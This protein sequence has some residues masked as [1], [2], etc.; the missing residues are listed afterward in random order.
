[1]SSES[2]KKKLR[3]IAL[4]VLRPGPPKPTKDVEELLISLSMQPKH[5]HQ[6]YRIFH[7]L[8]QGASDST[9]LESGQI[10][11]ESL[12]EIVP[13]RKVWVEKIL[14]NLCQLGACTDVLDWDTF[15]YLML[16]F[17]SLSKV[18]L[19]QC[20][21]FIIVKEVKSWTVHFLT[22]V[23]LQE[24]YEKYAKCPIASFSTKDISFARHMPLSRYYISDFVESCHRFSQLLNPAIH[25]QRAFQ[26]ALPSMDFWNNY[27]RMEVYNRK[28]TLDFFKLRKTH[29]FLR[30]IPPF[31]E[32][33]D[34][35]LPDTLGA[36]PI[37]AEQWKLRAPHYDVSQGVW[38]G[39]G[40]VPGAIDDRNTD[41]QKQQ[42][43]LSS[44]SSPLLIQAPTGMKAPL[45]AG[46]LPPV[47][48]AASPYP[49]R[50]DSVTQIGTQIQPPTGQPPELPRGVGNRVA[51]PK[52][53]DIGVEAVKH[54]VEGTLGGRHAP[55]DEGAPVG[56]LPA[57]IREYATIPVRRD[58]STRFLEADFIASSRDVKAKGKTQVESM[59]KLNPREL[60]QRHTTKKINVA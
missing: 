3:D 47:P 36:E 38:P 41:Q 51:I 7:A 55:P 20:M 57:W 21:F 39:A 60:F 58:T 6:L 4:A 8:K 19:A 43:L 12:I 31:R 18:E 30:G 40:R 9:M 49:G 56:A 44:A 34:L 50:P 17:C 32:S 15:L 29:F 16:R 35:L 10:R 5:L 25:L 2:I 53:R 28:I 33:C 48:A 23:Q 1:M 14:V 59:M 26:A 45:G 11:A 24:F 37:N 52:N 27:D 22:S 46:G 13:E 54:A 42:Q